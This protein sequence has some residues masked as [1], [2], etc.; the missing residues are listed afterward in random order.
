MCHQDAE[1]LTRR[2]LQEPGLLNGTYQNRLEM[3]VSG[4]EAPFYSL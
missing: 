1:A 3:W 2:T 4:T